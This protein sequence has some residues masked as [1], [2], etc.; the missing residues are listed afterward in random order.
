MTVSGL[1]FGEQ[2]LSPADQI[3][4]VDAL[5]NEFFPSRTGEIV[6]CPIFKHSNDQYDSDDLHS[7]DISLVEHIPED[8]TAAHVIIAGP[9]YEGKKMHATYMI[10]QDAW[11]GVSHMPVDW[12]GK[13]LSAI[14]KAKEHFKHYREEWKE[15]HIPQKDWLCVTVDYHR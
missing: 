3:P 9:D 2:E 11:N 5:W 6:P 13:V 8:L 4:M 1:Q 14:E 10:S 7:C 15:T 12:D